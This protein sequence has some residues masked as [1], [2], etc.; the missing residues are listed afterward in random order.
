VCILPV[1]RN[2]RKVKGSKFN[3]EI[4]LDK[5]ILGKLALKFKLREF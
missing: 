4:F 5:T 3:I 1:N 2:G